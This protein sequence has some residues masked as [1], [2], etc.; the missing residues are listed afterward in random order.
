MPGNTIIQRGT[1][2]TPG[3]NIYF[4]TTEDAE[5]PA[6]ELSVIVPAS[7]TQAGDIGNGFLPGQVGRIVDPF[8]FSYT[9]QNVEL[10]QGG[11]DTEGIEPFRERTR[12]APESWSTAG[13][14]GAYEYWAMT[15][16]PLII[17]VEVVTPS[18]GVVD[19]VPLLRGGEIPT[20]SILDEVY[21]ICSA[22]NRRPLT[23]HVIVR[24]PMPVE[25]DISFTYF[26]SRRDAAIGATLQQRVNQAVEDFVLWQK[27]KLGRDIT[28]SRLVEMVKS[29][30]IKRIDLDTLIP[31]FKILRYF[32][33]GV[34]R[35]VKAIYGGMEDD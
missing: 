19:I 26:I 31:S 24:A 11:A 33:L 25:Y 16:S 7:C 20:Q 34:A 17:D 1:R 23:D 6:G 13:P 5:I 4:A 10:T 32:E 2:A 3:N 21:K 15:A 22:D 30:G 14:Y 27:S 28:P 9:V 8:P 12:M 18:P 35:E 29:T